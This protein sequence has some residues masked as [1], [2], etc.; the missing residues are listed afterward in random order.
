MKL[1]I[2]PTFQRLLPALCHE[3]FTALRASIILEGC[4]DPLVV[5]R[6]Q[7]VDG[8]NR[9]EICQAEKIEFEVREMEFADEEAACD[10]IDKNQIARRNLT[11]DD[12]RLAVGRR[13]NRTKKA[14]GGDHK[15]TG[16]N[17]R[18]VNQ[19]ETIARESGVDERTVRRAGKLAEAVAQVEKDEPEVAAK[20]RISVFERAKES[21][22]PLV[23]LHTG[24][25]ESYT[26][27]EYLVSAISV[28][29]GIDLDPASNINAQKNVNAK[30]YFTKDEDGL[31]QKWTGRVWMN[32]PYT[33]RVINQFIE[34][35]VGHYRNG[36]IT[37]AIIL[38]NNNTD[39]SW[40]HIAAEHSAAVCFTRG[41]IN[42]LKT[43]GS[44]SSPTNG[45]C[46]IYFGKDAKKFKDVFG[47][48][49]LVMVKA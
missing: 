3:E 40:F 2:N 27:K 25:E 37:S 38:T 18:L 39:T 9:F 16:Q 7:I 17:V 29:G 33:A 10:W 13:Y 32:P 28:M 14:Q 20:G 26:P 47:A 35:L 48:H 31:K 42:F 19:A 45:Q 12:F 36:E 30:K 49:G 41:R 5:W 24:D 6:G 46:F 8:H 21:L 1:K 23:S 15:S 34:K 4:R 22:K 44:R 11:P 43:D